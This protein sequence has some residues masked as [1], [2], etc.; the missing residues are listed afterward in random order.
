M[1]NHENLSIK[2]LAE[3]EN[4]ILRLCNNIIATYQRYHAI[5]LSMLWVCQVTLALNGV[6]LKDYTA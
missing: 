4:L 2:N 1:L 3:R 6:K 5:Y